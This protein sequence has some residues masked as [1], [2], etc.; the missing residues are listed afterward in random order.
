MCGS[1]PHARFRSR[2]RNGKSTTVANLAVAVARAGKRVVV[3]DVDLR[4][5]FRQRPGRRLRRSGRVDHHLAA[6]V[7][8]LAGEVER[9]GRRACDQEEILAR[10]EV[11]AEPAQ[12]APGVA[13]VRVRGDA[14]PPLGVG[15]RLDRGRE[16]HR[17]QA[18][19]AAGGRPRRL[20]RT[21]AGT[22][23]EQG[24]LGTVGTQRR[25]ELRSKSTARGLRTSQ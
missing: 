4:R 3:V 5:G 24:Q 22:Q 11:A 20:Q 2:S 1:A 15:D 23:D 18:T 10:V 8:L 19:G 17:W 14:Q 13:C 9:V 25:A 12:G 6:V 16:A 7:Q 21:A